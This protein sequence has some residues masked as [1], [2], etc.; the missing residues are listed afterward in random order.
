LLQL[1]TA[2]WV[3]AITALHHAFKNLVMKRFIEVGLH[4]VMTTHA[5]L[6]FTDLEQMNR[7]E[8][9]LL[10]IRAA[11][12]GDRLCQVL[13]AGSCMRRMAIRATYVIAPVLTAAEV[14]TFFLACVAR[15]ARFRNLF[16]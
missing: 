2:V 15:K 1:E 13:V 4:F 3:V 6:R 10:G 9:G 5:E 16:R 14:V 11:Y 8:V 7:R 12:E